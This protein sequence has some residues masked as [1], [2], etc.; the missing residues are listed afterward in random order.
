MPHPRLLFRSAPA[1][2]LDNPNQSG[3]AFPSGAQWSPDASCIA[4]AQDGW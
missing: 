4:T 2:D 3:D 1:L